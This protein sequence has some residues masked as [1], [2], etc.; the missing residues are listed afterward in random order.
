[1]HEC[2]QQP[3]RPRL[4]VVPATTP[5]TTTSGEL[6][7]PLYIA[8]QITN[9]CNLACLH[10]IEESGPGKAFPDE[11]SRGTDIRRA[12]PDRRQR[13][14]VPVVLRRRANG[15]SVLLRHGRVRLQPRRAAQDRDQR[16]LP[17]A[18]K[19]RAAEG[20]RRQSGAGQPRWSVRRDFQQ[21]AGAGQFRRRARGH[22][23]PAGCR[24]ADRDQLLAHQLQRPRNRHRRST[25]RY[26]SARTASTPAAR[27]TPAT[28]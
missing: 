11:L 21:D 10:C 17:D 13:R 26:E 24:R 19:L 2:K 22:P 12:S 1:M 9:E 7:A 20:T 18:R 4:P 27:C 25:W 8:W 14:P 5:A 28:R 3:H 23:Q 15:S 16:P 6:S